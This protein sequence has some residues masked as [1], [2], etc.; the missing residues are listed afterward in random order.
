[1]VKLFESPLNKTI[2]NTRHMPSLIKLKTFFID[3]VRFVNDRPITTVSDQ[4]NDL[5]PITPSSFL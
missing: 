5:A 2:G 4:P 1:M 3:A